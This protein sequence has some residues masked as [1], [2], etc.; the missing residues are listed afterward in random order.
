MGQQS[1]K[2]IKARR[3]KSYLERKKEAAK[4]K[5]SAPKASK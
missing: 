1:N 3:R 2:I 5:K 4:A